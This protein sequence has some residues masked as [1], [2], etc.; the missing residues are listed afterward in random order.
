LSTAGSVA[1]VGV[2]E[3][4]ARVAS[5]LR[6]APGRPVH[7]ADELPAVLAAEPL[8]VILA[9]GWRPPGL[10]EQCDEWAFAKRKSWLPIVMSHPHIR[11]GPLVLPGQGPCFKCFET[12]AAQHSQ[13]SQTDSQRSQTDSQ[14]SQTGGEPADDQA[15]ENVT[16]RGYLAHHARLAAAVADLMLARAEPEA[17]PGMVASLNVL[18]TG[19]RWHTV[20]PVGRCQRCGGA[21]P[22]PA[23]ASLADLVARRGERR[24]AVAATVGSDR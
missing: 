1:I 15:P 19:V 24:L 22:G 20:I 14:R 4:G 12:R 18:G 21:D 7:R 8:T 3:F 6:R 9:A 13:R 2:G 17:R 11:I 10:P 5:L 23:R 16:P